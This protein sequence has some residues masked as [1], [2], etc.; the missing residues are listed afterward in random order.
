MSSLGQWAC[1]VIAAFL[2]IGGV[3]NIIGPTA[4]R[5]DYLRWGY[6][7]WFRF[8][9]GILLIAAGG[10]ILQPALLWWGLTLALIV[11]AAAIV[12]LLWHRE[13]SHMPPSV[14]LALLLIG[15]GY[16]YA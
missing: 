2:L 14:I 10:L 5:K 7:E 13:Y 9:T 4:M 11:T 12:T 3:V 15:I 6:P 16:L 1:W 8:V